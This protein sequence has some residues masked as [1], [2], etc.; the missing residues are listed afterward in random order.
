MKAMTKR[1][2]LFTRNTT[3]LRHLVAVIDGLALQ[4]IGHAGIALA[5]A[6]LRRR[7]EAKIRRL[8]AV[9]RN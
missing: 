1:A 9:S 4:R 7:I 2:H 3:E 5:L 6:E 8:E